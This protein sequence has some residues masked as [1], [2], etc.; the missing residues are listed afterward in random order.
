MYKVVMSSWGQC[1]HRGVGQRSTHC[2]PG[3]CELPGR[4]HSRG[5]CP[6]RA[7]P[8]PDG[9]TWIPRGPHAHAEPVSTR[10]PTGQGRAPAA[11]WT[12][13]PA[14]TGSPAARLCPETRGD[15]PV[16]S[17][18]TVPA[19]LFQIL[20]PP[21][22]SAPSSAPS[23]LSPAGRNTGTSS[24]RPA[25]MR[26]PQP[27]PPRPSQTTHLAMD[28]DHRTQQPPGASL[29]INVQHPQDLEE[30]DA[31]AGEMPLCPCPRLTGPG[32]SQQPQAPTRP[33]KAWLWVC[34]LTAVPAS[35]PLPPQAQ[36]QGWVRGGTPGPSWTCPPPNPF[37]PQT[38]FWARPWDHP[39][40]QMGK[41]RPPDG[42]GH[43]PRPRGALAG[44]QTRAADLAVAPE[45]VPPPSTLPRGPR[46]PSRES[47][48][49]RC[50]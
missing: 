41:L 33:L 21:C 11:A 42:G 16:F 13:R 26:A 5:A 30:A 4:R 7:R 37:G 24:A 35:P 10:L 12:D 28:E 48:W 8:V 46:T 14:Y 47:L 15:A 20:S 9:S 34:P 49:P 40:L 27:G 38:T 50:T 23:L 25:R 3:L 43:S 1:G 2:R 32:A 31:P 19:C 36:G 45:R 22:M 6:V 17:R 29:A 44:S 18:G 39:G